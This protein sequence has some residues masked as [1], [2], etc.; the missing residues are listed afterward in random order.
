MTLGTCHRTALQ[1]D[2]IIP[3]S[4]PTRGMRVTVPL[5]CHQRWLLS[6]VCIFKQLFLSKGITSIRLIQLGTPRGQ[7]REVVPASLCSSRAWCIFCPQ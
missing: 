1:K 2:R 6:F 4:L 7:G 5:R 3:T